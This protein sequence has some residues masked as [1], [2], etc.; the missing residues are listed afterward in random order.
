MKRF[1]ICCGDSNNPST[2]GGLSY[3][4]L[5]AGMKNGLLQGGLNLNP[6]KLRPLGYLWNLLQ[7]MKYGKAGGFQYSTLFNKLLFSQA[8]L[9]SSESLHFLSHYPALPPFPLPDKWQVDFYIDA[10]TSQIFDFYGTGIRINS[11]LK[12]Q[13][14]AREQFGYQRAGSVICRSEWAA[15]SVIND[16]SI[17]PKKVF[18]VPGGAN[19]SSNNQIKHNLLEHI[20]FPTKEKPLRLGFLGKDWHRKGGPFLIQLHEELKSI[21]IPSVIRCIGPNDKDMPSHEAIHNLGFIDKQKALN[22]F[23]EEISSWHFGTLFSTAEAFG[24]SNR[25]C[26]L[27]GV[28]V[29]SHAIGGIPSTIPDDDCGIIFPPNPNVSDVAKCIKSKIFPYEKYLKWRKRLSIRSTEFTWESS[30]DKLKQIIMN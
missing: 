16:Y 17:N 23:V 4:L 18:I 9:S 24:I 26:L 15:K 5:R 29:L 7:L 6:K 11:H 12:S 2:H 14:I 30:V 27:I 13:V 28:P 25:E 10:T 20:P 21:G 8:K 22:K 3:S 1:L 19:I